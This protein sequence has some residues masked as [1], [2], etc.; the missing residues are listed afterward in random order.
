MN[1]E[2][3]ERK[4]KSGPT[5]SHFERVGHPGAGS[6]NYGVPPAGVK[7]VPQ[8]GLSKTI[9]AVAEEFEEADIAEDLELLA[10]FG[11]D[12]VVVGVEFG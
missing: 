7:G 2:G 8:A 12:V 11:L 3:A 10:D 9:G 1:S 5:R 4:A 6:R